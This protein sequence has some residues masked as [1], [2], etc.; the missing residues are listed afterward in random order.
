MIESPPRTGDT[1]RT[2]PGRDGCRWARRGPFAGLLALVFLV[3]G[4][5]GSSEVPVPE[6][7]LPSVG[8]EIV[9]GEEVEF[10]W[11]PVDDADHY[12]FHLFNGVTGD[13]EQYYR[14]QAAPERICDASACRLVIKVELP[15]SDAHAW[16]VRAARGDDL[17]EWS[18]SLFT[19]APAGTG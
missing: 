15:E 14:S 10:V 4:G 3:V 2:R 12:D 6:N 1:P 18:R 17:S 19:V 9:A 7:A 11:A 16:R 13:I 5:C 8:A